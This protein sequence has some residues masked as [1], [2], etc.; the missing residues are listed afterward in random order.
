ME[1]KTIFLDGSDKGTR[2]VHNCGRIFQKEKRPHEGEPVW[3]VWVTANTSMWP[4]EEW[5]RGGSE[6]WMVRGS[7]TSSP[8]PP[9]L[10]DS[11]RGWTGLSIQSFLQFG[12][13]TAKGYNTKSGKGTL[14]KSG[15]NGAQASKGPLP[16]EPPTMRIDNT[17]NAV[18][19]E[20]SL[21]TQHPRFSLE[22]GWWHRT[23]CLRPPVEEQVFSTNHIVCINRCGTVSHSLQERVESLG[24]SKSLDAS[25]GPVLQ[26]DL[27]IA[28]SAQLH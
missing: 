23:L 12:F 7:V 21:E 26:V 2:Q 25:Q 13:I 9:G 8:W 3:H 17:W 27:R 16:L 4:G 5:E 24:K 14:V 10:S 19:Q 22:A 11:R 15:G 18:Y 1:K 28:V 6:V 20:S